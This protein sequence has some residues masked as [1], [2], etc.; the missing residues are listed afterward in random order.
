MPHGPSLI[1]SQQLCPK[2]SCIIFVFVLVQEEL[3]VLLLQVL[4]VAM[5]VI[6]SF[7]QLSGW[8]FVGGGGSIKPPKWVPGPVAINGKDGGSGGGGAGIV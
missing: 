2:C 6:S 4:E 8:F 3:V 1:G 5:E 7:S